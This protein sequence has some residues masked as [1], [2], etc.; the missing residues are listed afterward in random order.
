MTLPAVQTTP[1]ELFKLK[2]N[3]KKVDIRDDLCV[4][5]KR[6]FKLTLPLDYCLFFS[7]FF[8]FFFKTQICASLYTLHCVLFDGDSVLCIV[9]CLTGIYSCVPSCLTG[10]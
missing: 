4:L 6:T 3:N 5:W 7:S 8:F 9:S 2:K 10:I 1:S